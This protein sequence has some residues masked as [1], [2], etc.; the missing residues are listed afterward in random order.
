MIRVRR[1]KL[2][3]QKRS[4]WEPKEERQEPILCAGLLPAIKNLSFGQNKHY[5]TIQDNIPDILGITLI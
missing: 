2:V 3:S 5:P 4:D 1:V